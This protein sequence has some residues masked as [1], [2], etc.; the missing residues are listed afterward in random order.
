MSPEQPPTDRPFDELPPQTVVEPPRPERYPFWSYFDVVLFL[1]MALPSFLV[2]GLLARG[3]FALPRLNSLP[4]VAE[5]LTAQFAVYGILFGFLLLVFR[6]RYDKPLWHS[7]AWTRTRLPFLWIVISG[8]LTAL[9][10]VYAS[11]LIHTPDTPNPMTDLM[12]GRASVILMASFG[13]TVG[14][15]FEELGFRGFLQPLLVRT[16]GAALGILLTAIPFGL[17]HWQEYGNSWRHVVV[18]TL[19]G[20]AFGLMRH[21][22]GS[23]RAAVIMHASYNALF[24]IALLRKELPPGW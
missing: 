3:L 12:Q 4:K 20:A 13:V 8:F 15:L 2:A 19:A 7:L 21:V 10:V 14:P 18:I 22:T 17:L 9:L 6:A 11:S 1:G 16:F 5:L 23:T 24:F